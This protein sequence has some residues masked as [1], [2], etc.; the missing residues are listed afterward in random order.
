MATKTFKDI[1]K[2]FHK[3]L[4]T[5]FSGNKVL[6]KEGTIAFIDKHAKDNDVPPSTLETFKKEFLWI[7]DGKYYENLIA[8]V[9]LTEKVFMIRRKQKLT[10]ARR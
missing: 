5:Y 4:A 6:S 1:T 9:E 7:D 8:P 3:A 10:D 2:E